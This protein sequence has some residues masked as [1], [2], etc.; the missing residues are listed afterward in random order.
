MKAH[1]F[2][3]YATSIRLQELTRSLKKLP[4]YNGS[5]RFTLSKWYTY[6]YNT[7]CKLISS[8]PCR[9]CCLNSEQE[10]R[11]ASWCH[12]NAKLGYEFISH[13]RAMGTH[14]YRCHFLLFLI[15][16]HSFTYQAAFAFTGHLREWRSAIDI[17]LI[18]AGNYHI[19]DFSRALTISKMRLIEPLRAWDELKNIRFAPFHAISVLH[20]DER[21]G[22][23]WQ[24]RRISASP[25]A[26]TAD[27][28]ET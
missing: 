16:E 3:L 10:N 5:R 19:I 21:E 8:S 27:I 20:A 15:H 9:S 11:K 1:P 17:S 2:A 23:F 28:I 26:T 7:N 13:F 4:Q 14:A 25:P 24:P 22:H 6:S 12:L 18:L